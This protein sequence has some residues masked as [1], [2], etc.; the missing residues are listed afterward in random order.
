MFSKKFLRDP[1][2]SARFRIAVLA[3]TLVFVALT[4]CGGGG[5]GDAPA[6]VVTPPVGNSNG[7]PT[8]TLTYT[9]TPF[10]TS[11]PALTSTVSQAAANALVPGNCP[12][13]PASAYASTSVVVGS[14]T[15]TLSVNNLPAGF[16]GGSLALTKETPSNTSYLDLVPTTTGNASATLRQGSAALSYGTVYNGT[17]EMNFAGAPSA[18]KTITFTTGAD[19]AVNALTQAK[20]KIVPMGVQVKVPATEL[21]ASVTKTT[22]AGFLS[23]VL[24]GTVMLIDT[25]MK[26]TGWT[27]VADRTRD[28]VFAIYRQNGNYYIKV[29]FK[30]NLNATFANVDSGYDRVIVALSGFTF[31]RGQGA[32]DGLLVRSFSPSRN[33]DVCSLFYWVDPTSGFSAGFGAKESTA[34]PAWN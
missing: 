27:V 32:V 18:S 1:F 13:L 19:P 28:L 31:D 26:M 20:A 7:V 15:S 16:V 4:A 23:G 8:T 21:P 9:A 14:G 29:L 11:G 2:T 25:G 34:C 10:C 5:G 17:I 12:A 22:D 3:T 33:Q 24:N 30:D 6:P